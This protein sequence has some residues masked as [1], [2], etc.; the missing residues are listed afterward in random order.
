MMGLSGIEL[1]LYATFPDGNKVRLIRMALE[2]NEYYFS[3][4]LHRRPVPT[5]A[6]GLEVSGECSWSRPEKWCTIKVYKKVIGEDAEGL[7]NSDGSDWYLV[8]RMYMSK[9]DLD[10]EFYETLELDPN[11]EYRVILL[12]DDRDVVTN[13]NHTYCLNDYSDHEP[14]PDVDTDEDEW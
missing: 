9:V 14:S 4:D 12:H 8:D 2:T 3:S 5:G 13:G 6:T 7:M 10:G 11:A 1:E